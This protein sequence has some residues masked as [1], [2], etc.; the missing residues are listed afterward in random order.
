MVTI[1]GILLLNNKSKMPLNLKYQAEIIKGNISIDNEGIYL[2]ANDEVII[3]T[4]QR[5][6]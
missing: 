4:K 1:N 2:D 5:D 3:D 6:P